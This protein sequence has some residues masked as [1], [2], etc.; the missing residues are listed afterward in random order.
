MKIHNPNKRLNSLALQPSNSFKQHH[1]LNFLTSL[2]FHPESFHLRKASPKTLS[3]NLPFPMSKP[4]FFHIS[5]C[6]FSLY[7]ICSPIFLSLRS[8]F[9][10]L[11]SLFSLLSLIFTYSGFSIHPILFCI[12]QAFFFFCSPI[13]FYFHIAVYLSLF[14]YIFYIFVI[15]VAMPLS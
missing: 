15:I 1:S 14:L 11:S 6:S 7:A 2:P 4:L 12:I 10:V 3:S 13:L 8:L 9:S 5:F